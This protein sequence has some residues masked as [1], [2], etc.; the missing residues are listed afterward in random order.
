MII[1]IAENL[2]I[3]TLMIVESIA[4]SIFQLLVIVLCYM[5]NFSIKKGCLDTPFT[6]KLEIYLRLSAPEI[7]SAES[8]RSPCCILSTTSIPSVTLPKTA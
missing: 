6:V 5:K 8:M 1:F 3:R 7:T 2:L 4:V